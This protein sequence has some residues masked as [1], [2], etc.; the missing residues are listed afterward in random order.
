VRG[1]S[2]T[3]RLALT[4]RGPAPRAGARGQHEA[5]VRRSACD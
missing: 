2:M 1:A 4:V 3:A 5:S